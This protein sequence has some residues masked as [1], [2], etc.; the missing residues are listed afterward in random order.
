VSELNREIYE[1]FHPDEHRFVDRAWEWV[2][3]AHENHAVKRTDFLDPRQAYILTTLVRR[4][5]HVELRLDG[6]YPD[7]ERKRAL[8][9]PD[10]RWLDDEDIGI[11]VLSVV[12]V[13]NKYTELDHGDYMGAILGLGLKRD[14]IGDIHVLERGCHCLVADDIAEF[15]RLHLSKVHR[16]P[17]LTAVLPLAELQTAP[18]ALQELSVT[19]ASPRLDGIAGDVFRLSR[20]KVLE[21]IKAGKVKVNWKVEEDPAKPLKAGD[22]VSMAGFGR[23]KV[24][25]MDGVTKSG[26][27]RV[28]VAKF[29]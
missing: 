7:A 13:D 6:G 16:V 4:H 9:A 29:V 10:Y 11:K 21:P 8:V 17:V 25:E 19:V 14:K 23:F 26:R 1:H 5:G 27:T 12:P 22:V 24:L 15:I 2:C 3:K 20:S 28:K 18:A